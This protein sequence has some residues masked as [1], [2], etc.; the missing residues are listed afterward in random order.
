M[1][2]VG[3]NWKQFSGILWKKLGYLDDVSCN[4]AARLLCLTSFSQL[5]HNFCFGHLTKSWPNFFFLIKRICWSCLQKSCFQEAPISSPS[6][7]ALHILSFLFSIFFFECSKTFPSKL[8]K[9]NPS[10]SSSCSCLCFHPQTSKQPQFSYHPFSIKP[11][12]TKQKKQTQIREERRGRSHTLGVMQKLNP[13]QWKQGGKKN[14]KKHPTLVLSLQN[15]C[16][17]KKI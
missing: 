12:K 1:E 14:Q 3:F 15:L 13:K 5:F 7:H 16:S 2:R 8:G 4:R 10:S 6:P 9:K 11:G 17:T